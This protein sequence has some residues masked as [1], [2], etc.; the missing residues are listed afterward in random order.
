MPV[1]IEIVHNRAEASQYDSNASLNKGP[2]SPNGEDIVKSWVEGN[3]KSPNSPQSSRR[4]QNKANF[5]RNVLCRDHVG[6]GDESHSPDS[7][8]SPKKS[9]RK[10]MSPHKVK[11]GAE[12]RN[13]VESSDNCSDGDSI[14]E[15]VHP[16]VKRLRRK[17]VK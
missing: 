10:K 5:S 14:D 15:H 9:R 2:S 3:L 1:W 11:D 13:V 4:Q 16:E 12:N 8:S 17:K 6:S 7:T